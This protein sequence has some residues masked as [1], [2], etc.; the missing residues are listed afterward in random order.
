MPAPLGHKFS[1]GNQGG[2]PR[3]YDRLEIAQQMVD[4]AKNNPDCLTVPTFA[5]TVGIPTYKLRIWAS[6]CEKFRTLFL[7]ARDIIAQ[8]R[9]N[10]TLAGVLDSSIYRGTNHY[11]DYDIRDEIREEKTFDSGLR[12]QE[13]AGDAPTAAEEEAFKKVMAYYSNLN[14]SDKTNSTPNRSACETGESSTCL[15]SES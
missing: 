10:S 15:G 6:E 3:E 8:N 7:T 1:E 13:K 9:L 4:Y 14:S 5:I 11:Y 12:I 2:R